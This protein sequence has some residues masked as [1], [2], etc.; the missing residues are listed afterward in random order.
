MAAVY[1]IDTPFGIHLLR[2]IGGIF[3]Q[4][5]QD[6][7]QFESRTRVAPLAHR[8]VE[9]LG[10]LSLPDTSQIDHSLDPPGL[11]VHHHGATPLGVPFEQMLLQC[12]MGDVLD[13]GVDG[14]HQ[15]LP[16]DRV[17]L[18]PVGQRLPFAPELLHHPHPGSTL[19][20]K[21]VISL[22]TDIGPV[23]VR[24]TDQAVAHSPQ[25]VDALGVILDNKPAAHRRSLLGIVF[26][27]REGEQ[28]IPVGL[29]NIGRY[30]QIAVFLFARRVEI[31]APSGRGPR[32]EILGH[33]IAQGRD[34][35]FVLRIVVRLVGRHGRIPIHVVT[36]HGRG[37]QIPVRGVDVTPAGR[38]LAFFDTAGTRLATEFIARNGN[39]E[40]KKRHSHQQHEKSDRHHPD[41]QV[42]NALQ[43]VSL[44]GLRPIVRRLFCSLFDHPIT[45]FCPPVSY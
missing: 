36:Q 43:T 34:V 38:H 13:T 30:P 31:P 5:R 8:I 23:V 7:H 6:G 25:G 29:G 42:R 10:V 17:A 35:L 2:C 44:S 9:H 20:L 40:H 41:P 3:F 21:H 19:E 18:V 45:S 27:D 39:T 33:R 28:P 22:G 16:V 12:F 26:E 1:R 11:H 32:R 4:K 15:V 14:E 24:I 37:Q